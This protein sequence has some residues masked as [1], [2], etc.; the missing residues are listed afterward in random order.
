MFLLIGVYVLRDIYLRELERFS[1]L[2]FLQKASRFPPCLH[3]PWKTGR[4]I[5]SF[6]SNSPC[7]NG[8]FD[9]T[10]ELLPIAGGL[11]LAHAGDI[12]Q[13]LHAQGL[14]QRHLAEG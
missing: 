4:F 3:W 9:H 14:F 10:E 7:A 12:E 13:F 1:S 11:F 2:L 5:C 6:I 8:F